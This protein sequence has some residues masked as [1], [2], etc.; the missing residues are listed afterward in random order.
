MLRHRL[1][2]V[3]FVLNHSLIDIITHIPYIG[4]DPTSARAATWLNHGDL[5]P[6]LA[7]E[8]ALRDHRMDPA[9]DVDDLRHPKARRDAAERVGVVRRELRS[10]RQKVDGVARGERHGDVE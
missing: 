6:Q 9:H 10:A 3:H 4:A 5:P 8:E 2:L 1:W 7:G